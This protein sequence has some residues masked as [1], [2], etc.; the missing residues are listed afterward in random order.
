MDESQGLSGA[1][2]GKPIFSKIHPGNPAWIAQNAK[3]FVTQCLRSFAGAQDDNGEML[4]L[5]WP[6][7]LMQ[8]GVR[9][10]DHN[11]S[12]SMQLRFPDMTLLC[13][14]HGLISPHLINAISSVL[15]R[16]PQ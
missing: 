10:Y 7:T 15:R 14:F 5:F 9:V 6:G 16:S 13:F 12:P 1:V 3:N 2:L 4:R 11:A 8:Q